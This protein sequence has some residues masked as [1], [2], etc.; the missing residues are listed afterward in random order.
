MKTKKFIAKEA[1]K[2]YNKK[3]T[4]VTAQILTQKSKSIKIT[5]IIQ[6]KKFIGSYSLKGKVKVN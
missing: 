2:F 3:M 5:I 1:S 4:T 6:T